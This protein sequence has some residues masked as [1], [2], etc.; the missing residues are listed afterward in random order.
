[1]THVWK[2]GDCRAFLL[3]DKPLARKPA[4]SGKIGTVLVNRRFENVARRL[5][6]AQISR[7]V[8]F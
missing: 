2:A 5:G 3:S 1:M 8:N 7:L 6:V 4:E